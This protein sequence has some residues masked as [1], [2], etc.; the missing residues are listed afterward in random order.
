MRELWHP[1]LAVGK[2]VL[3]HPE[4][5]GEPCRGRPLYHVRVCAQAKCRGNFLREI[6]PVIL[7]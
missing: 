7:P 2:I 6:F 4:L 3:A 1:G 5:V